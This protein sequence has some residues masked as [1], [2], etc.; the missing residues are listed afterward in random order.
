MRWRRRYY[1]AP[2]MNGRTGTKVS[3]RHLPHHDDTTKVAPIIVP[4]FL[5]PNED[6]TD[7]LGGGRCFSRSRRLPDAERGF[8]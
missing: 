2:W 4:V 6:P 3:V 8:P 7:M 5:E 1:L